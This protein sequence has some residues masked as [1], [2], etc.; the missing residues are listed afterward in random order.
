MRKLFA[1]S[2]KY[3]LILLLSPIHIIYL[4]R[5]LFMVQS[6]KWL[7]KVKSRK[8]LAQKVCYIT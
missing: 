6:P 3:L 5:Y 8:F 2:S 4:L 7:N 1:H